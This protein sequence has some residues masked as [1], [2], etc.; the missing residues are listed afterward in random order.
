[1][2]HFT[3]MNMGSGRV[4]AVV[5]GGL[6]LIFC[7]ACQTTSRLCAPASHSETHLSGPSDSVPFDFLFTSTSQVN[8]DS[9]DMRLST[10]PQLGPTVNRAKQFL[11][12]AESQHTDGDTN[13][14]DSYFQA[15][16]LSWQ[17]M[18]EQL[19]PITST[20][21]TWVNYQESLR[22]LLESAARFGRL[23]G[24]RGLRVNQPDGPMDVPLVNRG[25]VWPVEQFRKFQFATP[26]LWPK[27]KCH[28]VS[29]GLGVPVV[30]IRNRQKSAKD[31]SYEKFFPAR[32]PVSVTYLLCP[33]DPTVVGETGCAASDFVL[34]LANPV[35]VDSVW[36]GRQIA[37]M[38]RD[39]SAAFEYQLA[40]QPNDPLAGLLTPSRVEEDGLRLL[41]PYQPG[42]IPVIFVHGLNSDPT[43]WS[44]MVN[45]LQAQ[46]WFNQYYQVWGFNYATGRP[47][48][49]SAL[50]LRQQMCE[51]L[52]LFDPHTEDPALR[53]IVLV[54][55]SMGGLVSK[56][57]VTES[58]DTIW[59]AVSHVPLESL[60]AMA[61][62][63]QELAERLYF[64]PQPVVQ[65][66]VY[67][68]TPHK[69]S[70]L[71]ARG[72]GRVSSALVRTDESLQRRHDAL[73]RNNPDAFTYPFRLRIPT[74]IDLLE[75]GDPTLQAIYG[76]PVASHVSQ[77]TILGTGATALT[78]RQGD[79]VVSVESASHPESVSEHHVAASHIKIL[80]ELETTQEVM[81][82]LLLHLEV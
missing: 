78:L 71:A 64:F 75:P 49:T 19:G 72:I 74:S 27:L 45:H 76:L 58:G 14:V 25:G 26:S 40:E 17:A 11:S 51:A 2:H 10:G 22:G 69:G 67:I 82:I 9:G 80:D 21:P 56:L 18:T 32:T 7:G 30:L 68:A 53:R 8:P 24:Y 28:Y 41:E 16:V 57:Q 1:M 36:V 29:S 60:K 13:C 66:V 6:V 33:R 65:R 79:G 38:A 47:F 34:E 81:R 63:K 62:M 35:R 4:C 61:E 46:P 48:V 73:V 23:D 20:S 5:C 54:G 43:A 44:E 70:S 50:R 42:K 12:L 77:H 39:L 55:H 52:A 15:T 37:P 59:S 31:G 3:T